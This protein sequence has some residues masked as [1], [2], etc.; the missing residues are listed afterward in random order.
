M[1]RSPYGE[2][3]AKRSFT[4]DYP[5]SPHPTVSKYLVS[6]KLGLMLNHVM[7]RVSNGLH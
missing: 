4:S 5:S 7:I 1:E 6:V 3:R 2:G